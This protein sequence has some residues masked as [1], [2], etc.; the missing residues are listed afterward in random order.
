MN[1]NFPL[2]LVIGSFVTGLIWLLDKFFFESSRKLNFDNATESANITNVQSSEYKEPV[3]VEISKF[4]F[5]VFIVVLVL[6]SFIVEPFRIPSGSMIPTLEI[7]DF[8]LVNKFTY[9]LRLPILNTKIVSFSEPE[10]GDVAVFRYPV[11]ERVDYIKRVI[12]LP[13][14]E[15]SYNNK[16]LYIN[17]EQIQVKEMARLLVANNEVIE[18]QESLGD[19]HH[20]MRTTSGYNQRNGETFIVPAGHYFVMGDNRD[21]SSDSRVWGFVPEAN[22]V[23]KAFVIWMNMRF[24]PL[25]WPKWDRIGTIIE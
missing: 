16:R 24:E 7:G 20:K 25:D 15:V 23:G 13:G 5:P 12:G 18:Y 10:R 14:D 3:F 11:D 2:I 6:R 17:G 4:L 19:I 8:I 9:G 22:L 1:I 21:N